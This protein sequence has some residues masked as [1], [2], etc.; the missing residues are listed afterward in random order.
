MNSSDFWEEPCGEWQ[1]VGGDDPDADV[2]Y[3]RMYPYLPDYLDGAGTGEIVLNIGIGQGVETA[4]LVASGAVIIGVDAAGAPAS[5]ARDRGAIGVRA[6]VLALPFRP[7]TVD[8]VVTIGCLHH[9]GSMLGGL[10]QIA[11]TLRPGGRLTLM[12]YGRWS[13]RRLNPLRW[14]RRRLHGRDASAALRAEYDIDS[15]GNAPPVTEFT[16]GR[17]LRKILR[18]TFDEVSVTRR[19]TGV[20]PRLRPFVLKARLDRVAGLDLYARARRR[21]QTRS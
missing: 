6:S 16:S 13:L 10:E 14:L 17:T 5:I 7:G 11:Q 12:V 15:S 2:A 3:W 19:N 18:P 20:R 21:H 8:A 1:F 9:T 4:Y